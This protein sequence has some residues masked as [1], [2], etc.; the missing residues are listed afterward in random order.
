MNTG[1]P[2]HCHQHSPSFHHTPQRLGCIHRHWHM[3][4]DPDL[5]R[6]PTE[7]T[8]QSYSTYSRVYQFIVT[9]TECADTNASTCTNYM[10]FSLRFV[11]TCNVWLAHHMVSRDTSSLHHC[12]RHSLSCDHINSLP[13][14]D[15][16]CRHDLCE[17]SISL[18][19][20]IWG[21]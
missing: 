5:V 8:I 10:W 9:H 16:K 3:Q 11:L 7:D 2:H 1:S 17:L 18:W 14:N 4:T 20:F 6:V 13:T 12:Y 15:G 19:E 21:F